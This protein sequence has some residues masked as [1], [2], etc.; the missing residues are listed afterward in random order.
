MTYYIDCLEGE[1]WWGGAVAQGIE[2]PV[3]STDSFEL[4]GTINRSDNQYNALFVSSRGRYIYAENGCIIRFEGNGQITLS[5]AKGEV[6][7]SEGHGT[8]KGAYRAAAA[9]HFYKGK[10]VPEA[11]ILTPQY[12]TWVEML[13]NVGE[14]KVEEYAAGILE[15]G[16]P[17]GILILDDGWMRT[18]GDWRFD[19][20]KFTD[21]QGMIARLHALGFKVVL[22]VC[23]FADPSM[24]DFAALAE[25]GAFVRDHTGAVAMR[26][27]WNGTSALFDMSSPAAAERLRRSFDALLAMGVDGFK[28]DA[29]DPCYYDSDDETF[30]KVTPNEQSKLWAE[31]AARYEYAELRACVG[32]AGY[33]IAQRLAD[34][35]SSW[36]GRKGILSLIP[37][38]LQAGLAGY[39]YCCPDMVGGGQEADFGSGKSHDDELM[40]RSCQC[41]ALMPMMQFSYAIWRR[42]AP[43]VQK[44]VKDCVGLRARYGDYLRGLLGEASRTGDPLM[45]HMEYEFPGQ[46]MEHVGDQFMLGSRLLVAPVLYKGMTERDVVLPRGCNWKY[47][48]TGQVYGGGTTVRASAPP[49]VLPYFERVQ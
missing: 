13:R 29:G 49:D 26:R 12:C 7:I 1:C 5:E 3:S 48:P 38:M 39:Q 34:K 4:N 15:S 45:R 23:P 11:M 9:R 18:Y 47:M 43:F 24:P 20:N 8:L 6:D 30:G 40:A 33:P 21:P 14:K 10:T 28:F 32:M 22:W 35:D 36:T 42:S 2:M 19:E 31:F 37:N 25:S 46:G 16:M 17:A 41:A 44:V 27:W